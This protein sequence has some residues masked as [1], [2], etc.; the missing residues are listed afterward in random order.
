MTPASLKPALFTFT[1]AYVLCL[2]L[3]Y[4][5]NLVIELP[6]SSA[7]GI[8]AFMAATMPAG[9]KFF[10]SYDRLPT[11]GERFRFAVMGS[12]I[13]MAISASVIV[14]SFQFYGIPFSLAVLAE[15]LGVPA[16]DLKPI[17]GIGLG[18]AILVGLLV[19]YFAFNIGAKSAAKAVQRQRTK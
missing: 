19:L 12:A 15:G 10:T 9:G 7:M 13:A 6:S 3:I 11:K 8:I 5:V 4:A 17:L 16:A 14:G 1:L 2:V 18:V